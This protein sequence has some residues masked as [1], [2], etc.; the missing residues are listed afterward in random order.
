MVQTYT[1]RTSG[2]DHG[3]LIERKQQLHEKC[4]REETKEKQPLSCFNN[5]QVDIIDVLSFSYMQ[6]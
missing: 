3:E 5:N 6:K 1:E 4:V 2:A